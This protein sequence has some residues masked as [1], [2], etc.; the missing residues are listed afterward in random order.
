MKGI[1]KIGIIINKE[2]RRSLIE[3]YNSYES[4]KLNY[5]NEYQKTLG[6]IHKLIFD[7]IPALYTMDNS[8]LF[9]LFKDQRVRNRFEGNFVIGQNRR[10]RQLKQVNQ[11]MLDKLNKYTKN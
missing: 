1:G 3:T 2:V 6:E 9:E 10:L 5:E 11:N 8:S 7:D 4:Y